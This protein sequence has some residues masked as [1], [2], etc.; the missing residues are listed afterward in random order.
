MNNDIKCEEAATILIDTVRNKVIN[1]DKNSNKSSDNSSDYKETNEESK[2]YLD[3]ITC[4]IIY[5]D[6]K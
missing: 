6:I 3:N 1:N 4:I 2:K 5:L